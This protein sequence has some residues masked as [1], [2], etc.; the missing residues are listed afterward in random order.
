[1]ALAARKVAWM[2]V[3]EAGQPDL[4]QRGAGTDEIAADGQRDLFV[5]P[6]LDEITPRILREVARAALPGDAAALRLEQPRSEL[7]QRR[8]ARPVRTD[9]HD[10]L[11]PADAQACPLHHRR[12]V[13]GERN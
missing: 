10:D 9:E 5:G 7:R 2:A 12:C 1:L 4:R 8:L 13:V 3:F 11:A 6:L